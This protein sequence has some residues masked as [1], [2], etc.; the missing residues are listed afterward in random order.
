MGYQG[1][2]FQLK[3]EI[4]PYLSCCHGLQST[5]YYQVLNKQKNYNTINIFYLVYFSVPSIN[6]A[7]YRYLSG[8]VAQIVFKFLLSV[9][10][11]L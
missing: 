6:I 7:T 5:L 1:M 11:F 3:Y 9:K 4:R 10:F 8:F 2:M